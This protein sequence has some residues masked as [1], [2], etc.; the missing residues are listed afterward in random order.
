MAAGRGEEE[1]GGKGGQGSH[2]TGNES[3]AAVAAAARLAVQPPEVSGKQRNLISVKACQTPPPRS[4]PSAT[5]PATAAAAACVPA[6]PAGH[7]H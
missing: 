5:P 4:L 3:C 2:I 1:K 6:T 7:A